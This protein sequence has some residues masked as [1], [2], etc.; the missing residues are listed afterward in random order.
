MSMTIK[1]FCK[2]H[3]ACS[4]CYKWAMATGEPDMAALWT[5]SDIPANWRVW[6][7]T[8]PGVMPDRELRLFACWCGRLIRHLLTDERSRHAVEVA[9]LYVEGKATSDELAA[10]GAAA[11]AA[12]SAYLLKHTH[13]RF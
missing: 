3:Y 9:E 10:A 6:I 11:R 13:P 12:Q 8:R 7:A 1:E 4:E 2:K 5:R